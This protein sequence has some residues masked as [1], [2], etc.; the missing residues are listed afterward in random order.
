MTRIQK[1]S[2]ERDLMR[3]FLAD[4]QQ[5][6]VPV[7]L[8]PRLHF[9]TGAERKNFRLISQGKGIHWP[10]IEED[11]SLEGLLQRR[12]SYESPQS[13]LRWISDRKSKATPSKSALVEIQIMP[14]TSRRAHVGR[15]ARARP[16]Q[17]HLRE[18]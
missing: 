17:A 1:V 18:A 15:L 4:G 16:T 2:F 11:I 6:F 7:K 12:G 8:Y 3:V 13:V 14:A 10:D 9:A 5:I